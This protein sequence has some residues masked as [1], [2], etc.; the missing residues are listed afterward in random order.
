MKKRKAIL[1]IITALLMLFCCV[2]CVNDYN[3]NNT[4]AL[5]ILGKKSDMEKTYMQRIFNAYKERTGNEIKIVEYE[6]KDYET[7]A[8]SDFA[9]NKAPDI[10]F[11]FHNADLARFD[12]EN[13]FYYLDDESWVSDLTKSAKAYCT[14][15]N[16]RLLGLPFWE[17][18]VSGCYYNKTLL[19]EMGLDRAHTQDEFDTLCRN[20]IESSNGNIAPICWP[21]NG[22][23]WM[24]QFGLDPIFADKPDGPELLSKLN[25]N[26]ITYSDIPQFENMIGWL[27]S[28]AKNGWFGNDYLKV[29]WDE[30]SSKLGSGEAVMTFIWDTWFDTDFKSGKYDKDDFAVMP[31]FLNTVSGGT[32]EG[33]NL[34]MMMVNKNSEKLES[35]LEFLEFCA[36]PDNY[37]MAFENISTVKCFEGMTTNKTSPIVEN[38]ADSISE[39]ERVSTAST[40]I[41]AYSADEMC[42]ILNDM[43]KGTLSVK[44]CIARMDEDRISNAKKIGAENF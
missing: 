18:S 7:K 37:N 30:I 29:G 27:N 35:A 43:F 24:L 11:H 21:G 14:D 20:I 6:D 1:A 34:N 16:G 12:V 10:F 38:A 39:K 33:G 32:Y 2:A 19:S 41:I 8:L 15:E 28:A 5:I 26:E 23:S 17:S 9:N 22:C 25:K 31:I 44:E 40:K 3:D 4:D 36:T 42:A 13:N